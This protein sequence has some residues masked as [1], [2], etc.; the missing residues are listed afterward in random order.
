MEFRW[1]QL[2][3]GKGEAKLFV[4][5]SGFVCHYLSATPS[6]KV[7][8]FFDSSSTL[9]C[10]A[11]SGK[12]R[13]GTAGLRSDGVHHSKLPVGQNLGFLDWVTEVCG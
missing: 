4:C 11:V 9:M 6:T 3:V 10:C 2:G 8:F 5:A 12:P 13:L 1:E 7:G